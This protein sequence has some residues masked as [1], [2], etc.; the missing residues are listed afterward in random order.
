MR[1][2]L[3]LAILASFAMV[4]CVK[5]EIGNKESNPVKK[6]GFESPLLYDNVKETK[7]PIPGEIADNIY[8]MSEKFIIYAAQH[9]GDFVA[10]PEDDTNLPVG[11]TDDGL[12]PFNGA[13]LE[14]I[15]TF[16]AWVPTY[17]DNGVTKYYYW[18]LGKQLTFSAVSPAEMPRT[19]V[20]YGPQGLDIT[21]FTVEE[22]ATEQIDVMFA[23]RMTNQT[24]DNMVS[25]AAEY[26]GVQLYFQHALS[27]IHFSISKAAME[28]AVQLLEITL[29]NVYGSGDFSENIE[30]E[31]VIYEVGNNVDPKWNVAGNNQCAYNSFSGE[32]DFPVQPQFVTEIVKELENQ[33]PAGTQTSQHSSPLLIVPQEISEDAE[34]YV[35]YKVNDTEQ[36]E[37]YKLKGLRTVSTG[38]IENSVQK[39]EVIS[40]WKVGHKYTYRL[41]Y[42]AE[43]AT[44]NIIMFGPN[45]T[46]WTQVQVIQLNL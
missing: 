20:S 45:V 35:K 28:H 11:S 29:K 1:T 16:D 41:H 4:G 24:A 13:V 44:S 30:N 17:V 40:E 25:S 2:K 18:P 34:L 26:S 9:T 21:G 37:T 46:D 7:A 38:G 36:E 3:F 42:S 5:E 15:Q 39:D 33:Q 6:I 22:D 14:R 12:C 27:S 31:T 43:T 19:S 23:Q 32:I 10:W 8:P